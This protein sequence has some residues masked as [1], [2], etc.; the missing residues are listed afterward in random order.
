[1]CARESVF[2]IPP[3]GLEPATSGFGSQ[4]SIQLSYG[5]L[6]GE[7]TRVNGRITGG[8]ILDNS[9]PQQSMN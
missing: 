9:F 7:Q 2:Q 5:G 4:H 3:A 6:K 8:L 1:M